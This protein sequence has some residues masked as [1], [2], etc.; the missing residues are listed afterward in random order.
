M[1]R[2]DGDAAFEEE[3]EAKDPALEEEEEAKD[4]ALEKEE[5]AQDPAIEEEEEAKDQRGRSEGTLLVSAADLKAV[6]HVCLEKPAVKR[7]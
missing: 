2:L 6:Q 5:E 3:E 4:P 1:C 7:R